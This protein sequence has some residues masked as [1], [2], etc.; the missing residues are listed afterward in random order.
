[1]KSIASI[2]LILLCTSSLLA[3]PTEV[4]R[5]FLTLMVI[6]Y[7]QSD[8]SVREVIEDGKLVRAVIGQVNDLFSERGY[9]TKD[10]TAITKLSQVAPLAVD[11]ERTEIKE[12]IQNSGVDIVIYV[13]I[14]PRE[15]P[16]G[17]RQLQLSLQAIDL[18]SA[19]N[20]ANSVSVESN[21]RNY[22]DVNMV[23]A[24]T[25]N[26]FTQQLGEFVD[27]LDKKMVDLIM[28]GRT[29]TIK[30]NLLPDSNLD[31]G[32]VVDEKNMDLSGVI[33]SWVRSNT[34]RIYPPSG[35][36][37]F[38]QAE[39]KIPVFDS[40]NQIVTP[41][42]FRTDFRKYLEQIHLSREPLEVVNMVTINSVIQ[43]E[44]R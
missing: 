13:E 43:V 19:E 37:D 1:M 28:N 36:F 11:L 18:Y 39:C 5:S 17:D 3:Q 2:L 30:V 35:D 12:A 14:T 32:S 25:D 38:W 33:E 16:Q 15:Y 20:Y 10:Y 24:V 8:Q 22:T 29:V 9:R 23:K 42:S 31:L 21:R 7:T 44:L 6:P 34:S 40:T 4:D 41:H 27:R 26:Q